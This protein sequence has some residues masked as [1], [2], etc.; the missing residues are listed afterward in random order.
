[1]NDF[2]GQTEKYFRIRTSYTQQTYNILG[3]DSAYYTT[4]YFNIGKFN[5]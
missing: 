5:P 1:M 4:V 3:M 2:I